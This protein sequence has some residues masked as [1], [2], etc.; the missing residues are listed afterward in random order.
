MGQGKN[1]NDKIYI[2]TI[3]RTIWNGFIW[4]SDTQ[5][6]IYVS[7]SALVLACAVYMCEEHKH[8]SHHFDSKSMQTKAGSPRWNGKVNASES[9]SIELN[10][11]MSILSHVQIKMFDLYLCV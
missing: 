7:V 2:T 11:S 4:D 6:L 10:K 5:L 1:R 8:W 9:E 3:H